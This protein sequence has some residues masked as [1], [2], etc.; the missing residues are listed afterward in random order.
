[1]RDDPAGNVSGTPTFLLCVRGSRRILVAHAL[2]RAVSA[3]PPTL[4]TFAIPRQRHERESIPGGNV[5]GATNLGG[6]RRR[7]GRLKIGRRMKSCPTTD[8][9]PPVLSVACRKVCGE[10]RCGTQECVRHVG[11]SVIF[12]SPQRGLW[13]VVT[14]LATASSIGLNP[15]RLSPRRS[16]GHKKP[17]GWLSAPHPRS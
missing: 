7:A 8:V 3:L 11:P 5:S 10:C 17:A 13:K 2:L 15:P 12:N 1:M 6:K 9:G 16:H 4:G 14:F